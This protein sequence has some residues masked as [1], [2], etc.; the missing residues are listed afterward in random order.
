MLDG[1]S[2]SSLSTSFNCR[3]VEFR[4]L[5]TSFKAFSRPV[6]SPSKGIAIPFILLALLPLL[7]SC[8]YLLV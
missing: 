8:L 3:C 2:L 1:S 6:A 5:F 7:I 4:I